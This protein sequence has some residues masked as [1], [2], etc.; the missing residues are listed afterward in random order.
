MTEFST[1]SLAAWRE[2]HAFG[3]LD[4]V[5]PEG[6]GFL[7]ET[8]SGHDPSDMSAWVTMSETQLRAHLAER[9]F[10]DIAAEEAI[11][12]SRQWA[13]TVTG[14]SVFPTPRQ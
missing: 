5:G 9:G 11:E 12:L 13:T 10:S 3:I 7:V 4:I 1:T 14:T 2:S 6:E 8:R